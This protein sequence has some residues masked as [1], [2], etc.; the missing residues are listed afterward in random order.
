MVEQVS[1]LASLI[2]KSPLFEINVDGIE[3][4]HAPCGLT[5]CEQLGRCEGER[6][7]EVRLEF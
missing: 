2:H 6:L 4:G 1:R 5:Q 7:S 3:D